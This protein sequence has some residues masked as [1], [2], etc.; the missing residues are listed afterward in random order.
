MVT[1]RDHDPGII[2]HYGYYNR[3]CII[4]RIYLPAIYYCPDLQK[5]KQHLVLSLEYDMKQ[6]V[7][8]LKFRVWGFVLSI[9]L[10]VE[11]KHPM[12]INN[13][14]LTILDFSNKT[15]ILQ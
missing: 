7:S 12:V 2:L 5:T 6:I 1:V 9:L 4:Q 15:G 11:R 10:K 3:I 14:P 8:G 13:M